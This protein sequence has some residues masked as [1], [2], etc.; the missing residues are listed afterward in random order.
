MAKMIEKAKMAAMTGSSFKPDI[1]SPRASPP[2]TP[3]PRFASTEEG[4]KT[5][6]MKAKR[7]KTVG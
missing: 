1:V 6:E 2:P 3:P 7:P 5:I 4:K